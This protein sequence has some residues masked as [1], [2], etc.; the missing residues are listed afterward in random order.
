MRR[1]TGV[2]SWIVIILTLEM[3]FSAE[4]Q[5]VLLQ[6]S[7]A[8]SLHAREER[9][10]STPAF[11][12]FGITITQQLSSNVAD[13]PAVSTAPGITFSYDPGTQ[14][15]ERSSTSLGPV[16]VERARTIG[17]GKFE[18]GASYLFIDF[19]ELDGRNVDGF[20]LGPRVGGSGGSIVIE[21][22]D[23][24]QHVI[25]LFATYGITDRWD[26]NLLLPI[27]DSAFNARVGVGFG[28]QQFT[29]AGKNSSVGVGDLFLRTKY[30]LFGFNQFNVAVGSVIR[31]PTGDEEDLRGKGDFILEP[32]L[33]A[34]QEYD[35]FHLH[36]SSG[37]EVNVDDSD[38]SRVRYS[39]GVAVDILK[40]QLA[41][42]LDLIGSSNLKTDR[43]V[44]PVPSFGGGGPLPPGVP[45]L[46]SQFVTPINTNIIDIGLGFKGSIG[47]VT[48]F[49]TAFLPI[50]DDGL[51]ADWIPAFGIQMGF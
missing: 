15:F 40:Q 36:L 4:A 26:V 3:A 8:A 6:T 25:P 47:P 27:I 35:R 28:G 2:K 21:K 34:S 5:N 46:P 16:F 14:L 37:L 9:R 31:F 48:G 11:G 44:G 17:Q 49:F 23:L 1:T 41:L 50:T 42:T 33:A 24:R 22:F 20:T 19:T 51:R 39:G 43:V 45:S 32:F 13:F 12:D 7:R 18:F 10:A 29:F 30:R 38:R